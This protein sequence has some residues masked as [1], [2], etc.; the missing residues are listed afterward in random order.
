MP[1]SPGET[2]DTCWRTA[3]FVGAKDQGYLADDWPFCNVCGQFHSG[4]AK[5]RLALL[6][7]AG[8]ES[9]LPQRKGLHDAN[10]WQLLWADHRLAQVRGNPLKQIAAKT[11][12]R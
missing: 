12:E 6:T 11:F 5:G 2:A 4:G 3:A 10:W 1:P 7:H 8:P 9:A